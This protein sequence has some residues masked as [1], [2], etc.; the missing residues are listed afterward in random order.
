M[1]FLIDA[2]QQPCTVREGVA[3]LNCSCRCRRYSECDRQCLPETT[4][5]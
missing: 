5:C 1:L 4:T 3:P 2:L